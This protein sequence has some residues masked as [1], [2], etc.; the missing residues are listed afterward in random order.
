MN[1]LIGYGSLIN[2]LSLAGRETNYSNIDKRYKEDIRLKQKWDVKNQIDKLEELLSD[3]LKFYPVKI[4]GYKRY[5]GIKHRDGG[6]LEVYESTSSW[7]N[8][9]LYTNVP[10]SIY[11]SVVNS[12]SSGYNVNTVSTRDFTYYNNKPEKYA[13][14][15]IFAPKKSNPR[16][17]ISKHKTYHDGILRGFVYLYESDYIN[18]EI[19]DEFIVDFLETTY[20]YKDD[21]WKSLI[22]IQGQQNDLDRVK[23]V[24][25]NK[26]DNYFNSSR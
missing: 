7:I 13:E 22:Q 16:N 15:S 18:N 8:G 2:P 14:T 12:E 6:M 20:E 3:G 17:D 10:D 19:L 24:I 26:E 25:K 9:M 23:N 4:K 11:D 5:Y 1:S 21:E